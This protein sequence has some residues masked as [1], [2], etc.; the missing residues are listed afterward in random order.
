MG[1]P[2]RFT[3]RLSDPLAWTV[4]VLDGAGTT[5][6]SGAGS[7]T[8]VDW[9]WNAGS[10]VPGRYTYRMEAGTDVRPATGP[11][12]DTPPLELSALTTDTPVV[13]PNGDDRT[14]SQAV[15]V[16]VN[17]TAALDLRLEN[18][19]GAT[20]ATFATKRALGP[21]TTAIVWQD[22]RAPDG[23]V[24][25]DGRYTFVAD[26][27]A[28]VEHKTTRRAITVDR[29]LGHVDVAPTPFS[30]NGDGRRD[31]VAVG[32]T[33]SRQASALVRVY[34]GS[35]VVATLVNGTR[36]AG[37]TEL[38]WSGTGTGDGS[39][40]VLVRATTTAFGQRNQERSLVR[41]TR[42]PAVKVLGVR[43]LRR[44]TY[45]R[46]RLDEPAAV[47]VRYGAKTVQ[48][49]GGAG[50]LALWRA[51]RPS[52]VTITATDRSRERDL[53][54]AARPPALAQE[55]NLAALDEPRLVADP[56]LEPPRAVD[57]DRRPF[58]PVHG[59]P[60]VAQE[61]A[62]P[63]VVVERVEPARRASGR[64]RPRVSARSAARSGAALPATPSTRAE[65]A[66]RDGRIRR[67][68][69]ARL[70]HVQ[71]DAEDD[72][73]VPRLGED[74]GDLAPV[75]HHV[76]R[77]LDLARE[78]ERLLD[79]ERGRDAADEGE[80]GRRALRGRP[81]QRPRQ[82][83]PA[84][85]RRRPTSGPSRPRPA[86]C[87]SQTATAPSASSASSSDWRRRAPLGEAIGPAERP[88]RSGSTASGASDGPPG[89]TPPMASRLLRP[90]N[91]ACRISVCPRNACPSRS[92]RRTASSA[93]SR[94]S[95]RRVPATGRRSTSSSSGT[96][97][98]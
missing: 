15:R 82:R 63:E 68:L 95:R 89:S 72:R 19:S 74:A 8:L 49:S 27:T 46:F 93:T 1:G 36:S 84:P 43:R 77:P 87:S 81:E 57:H 92:S 85:G 90:C 32:F 13:T 52:V 60:A 58:V 24:V 55:A 9:T 20:V 28:G 75:D 64:T 12:G 39:L 62:R 3:A 98:A 5:V 69:V 70:V 76:V 66:G 59:D 44:G 31:T 88:A 21:G 83:I 80:L 67:Q 14:D 96:R 42:A 73:A 94:S 48:L 26:V 30:P 51:Y 65:R 86:V 91:R 79:R 2:I 47:T 6:A 11:V 45:V 33:L 29:T 17:R 78:P 50:I 38:T 37:R 25:P 34:R 40:R 16:T 23:T 53:G 61:V 4:T 41:D 54:H 10:A 35:T 56:H 7:G 18:A 97:R 71:A 22:G